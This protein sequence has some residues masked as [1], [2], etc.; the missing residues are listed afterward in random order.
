MIYVGLDQ[1]YDIL[2][3]KQHNFLGYL[4]IRKSDQATAPPSLS[5]SWEWFQKWFL[6]N[7]CHASC[8][9]QI[10]ADMIGFSWIYNMYVYIYIYY[11]IV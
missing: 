1:T 11:N 10:L 4:G 3:K 5:P 8:T 2:L 9:T 6:I 7:P